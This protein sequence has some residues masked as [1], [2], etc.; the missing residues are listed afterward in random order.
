MW[1]LSFGNNIISEPVG[2]RIL[3]HDPAGNL[4]ELFHP[5]NR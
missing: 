1:R 3:L 4:V 5:A 2:Q